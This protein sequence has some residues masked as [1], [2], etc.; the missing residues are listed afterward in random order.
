MS[1]KNDKKKLREKYAGICR[2]IDE[3]TIIDASETVCENILSLITSKGMDRIFCYLSFGYEIRTDMLVDAILDAGKHVYVP[4]IDGEDMHAVCYEKG[5][6]LEVNSYGISEPAEKTIYSGQLDIAVVPGLAY[7]EHFRRLGHG[8]AYYDRFLRN[9]NIFKAGAFGS[10]Q[11]TDEVPNNQYD[12]VL[13]AVFTE[14]S[15]IFLYN[16]YRI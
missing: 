9:R 7:D 6:D 13:D 12:V 1:I 11:K 14:K 5:M 16:N 8:K 3:R 15:T 2:S 10:W 4:Y